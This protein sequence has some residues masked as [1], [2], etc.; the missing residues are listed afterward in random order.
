MALSK[1]KML[2]WS[3]ELGLR[4]PAPC[5]GVCHLWFY[6]WF[7]SPRLCVPPCPGLPELLG[8]LGPA[9]Q[10][11]QICPL[12]SVAAYLPITVSASRL[13]GEPAVFVLLLG[14]AE[15]C[16]HLQSCVLGWSE[17]ACGC[18]ALLAGPRWQQGLTEMG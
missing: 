13:W 11:P 4:V 15:L 14:G 7:I 5:F 6:K 9:F 18:W 1:D 2:C 10:R 3:P 12:C 8:S 17:P 16:H